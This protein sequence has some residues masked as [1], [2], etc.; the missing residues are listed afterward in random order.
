MSVVGLSKGLI[1][2]GFVESGKARSKLTLDQ[3][4]SR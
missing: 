3:N 1:P 4:R 2:E